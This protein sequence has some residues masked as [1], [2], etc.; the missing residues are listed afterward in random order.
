MLLFKADDLLLGQ[1]VSFK[2]QATTFSGLQ[3]SIYVSL[4]VH[5][6]YATLPISLAL[7][8]G[9]NYTHNSNQVR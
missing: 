1:T 8:E 3:A 9:R 2:F 7:R 6:A 4:P 5:L